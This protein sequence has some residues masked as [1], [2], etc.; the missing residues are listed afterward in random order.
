MTDQSIVQDVLNAFEYELNAQRDLRDSSEDNFEYLRGNQWVRHGS[1]KAALEKDGKPVLNLNL[2]LPIVTLIMGYNVQNRYDMK[3][4]AAGM[5]TSDFQAQLITKLLKY[6]Q[7]ESRMQYEMGLAILD[8]LVANIG[9][10][11]AIDWTNENNPMGDFVIRRES[12]FYH[13]RDSNNERYDINCGMYHIRTKWL[14]KDQLKNMYP[15]RTDLID[16][17]T[18]AAKDGRWQGFMSDMWKRFTRSKQPTS[19]DY[20]NIKDGLYRVIE[21]WEMNHIHDNAL[22]NLSTDDI[23]VIPKKDVGRVKEFIGQSGSRMYEM[24]KVKRKELRVKT[25]L[26]NADVLVDNQLYDVQ[27]GK[28]PFVNLFTYWIDGHGMSNI[29][30]LKDY[31]D[32]HNKRSSQILHILNSMGNAGWWVREMH[33]GK[34]SVDVDDLVA[35]NTKLGWVGKYKGDKPPEKIEPNQL[36]YGHAYLD[37]QARTGIR[38]TSGIGENIKGGQESSGESGRLFQSRV[39]QGEIMLS[40]FFDNMKQSKEMIGSYLVDAYPKMYDTERIFQ[41]T[42]DET[43]S[44]LFSIN[45]NAIDDI[46]KGKFKIALDETDNSPTAKVQEFVELMSLVSAMPPEMVNWADVLRAAPFQH[47]EK[48]AQY[49]E[50]VMG[51]KAQAEQMMQM[52]GIGQQI[53]AGTQ[54]EKNI[55]NI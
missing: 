39:K 15:D 1:A 30:N 3:A 26:A 31:Q 18:Q 54:D 22:Y 4:F 24:T 13:F 37:E 34:P 7:I 44:E 9:G 53:A 38:A 11:L 21:L 43:N 52:Q 19:Y 47:K 14:S 16:R 8:A 51:M 27:N 12:P 5:G 32:E 40:H 17:Y 42:I 10:Y 36:P 41:I 23:V 48:M 49:A 33:D 50:Q 45:S 25:V 28:F 20:V 6:T 35:N 46:T 2:I 29:E 55:N